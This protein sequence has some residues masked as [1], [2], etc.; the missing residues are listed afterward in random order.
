MNPIATSAKRAGT[1]FV[2]FEAHFPDS[3]ACLDH[4][5]RVRFGEMPKCSGCGE[6]TK[7]LRVRGT[8]RYISSCCFDQSIN[9]LRGTIFFKSKVPLVDWFRCILYFTNAAGGVPL[10]FVRRQFDLSHK[11][12]FRMCSKI[13][14]HLNRIDSGIELGRAGR[15]FIDETIIRNVAASPGGRVTPVRV[16]IACDGTE[17]LAFPIAPGRLKARCKPVFDRIADDADVVVRGEGLFR[18]ITGYRNSKSRHGKA[19]SVSED[20]RSD[21]CDAIDSYEIKLKQFIF[22]SHIWVTRKYLEGYV[23]HFGFL[24]RRRG[25]GA[26]AFNDAISIFR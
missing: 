19:I 6:Q 1:S 20:I 22:R 16:L 2:E 23:A 21:A 25:K 4:L 10:S 11:A 17:L 3:S 9:P 15:V 18:R 12:A 26:S 13:R 8:N 5:L 14:M 7:F 24:Y